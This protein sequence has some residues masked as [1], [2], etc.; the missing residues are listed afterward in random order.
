MK[1]LFAKYLTMKGKYQVGDIIQLGLMYEILKDD[2]DVF[3]AEKFKYPKV[4]LFLCTKE[5]PKE[6]SGNIV[7][8][9]AMGWGSLY[10]WILTD[11]A[12]VSFDNID[13]DTSGYNHSN[14]DLK[15]NKLVFVL[16][17][18]SP[19]AIWIKEGDEFSDEEIKKYWQPGGFGSETWNL[20][21]S[22]ILH[23]LPSN[24]TMMYK[25]KG[26]CGLFH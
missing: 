6:Q 15:K 11:F 1:Q 14:V 21:D 9:E 22:T 23:E 3:M 10:S 19:N 18:I 4:Q 8:H 25:V 5:I 20:V 24:A 26:C 7:Y 17:A 12:H 16:G 2:E 13:Y